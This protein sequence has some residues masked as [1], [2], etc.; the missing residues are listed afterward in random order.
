[1]ASTT[2]INTNAQVARA[3]AR[4][5]P[6]AYPRALEELNHSRLEA[7]TYLA[8]APVIDV[9]ERA[10]RSHLVLVLA[11][12]AGS[13]VRGASGT[14]HGISC[15]LTM[16]AKQSK[17]TGF[18]HEAVRFSFQQCTHVIPKKNKVILE[19]VSGSVVGGQ[20]LAIVGPSGA[21]KTM[22]MKLLTLENAPGAR[23]GIVKLDG[24]VLGPDHYRKFCASVPQVETL[25]TF[26]TA[27]DHLYYA[28]RFYHPHKSELEVQTEVDRML[29][30]TGLE[31]CQNT[32]AGNALIAGLSGG[33]RRRLS[34]ACGLLKS[35]RVLFLDEPTSGLDAAAAAS[36]VQ[37]LRNV[38][39]HTG[40]AVVCTIHQPSSRVFH[41]FDRVLLLSGGRP[42]Y[43]GKLA[44]LT[45]YLEK[46]GH[47]LP[48]GHNVADFALELVNRDF[49]EPKKVET[50]IRSWNSGH[51]PLAEE[52][53][54]QA[55]EAAQASGTTA[56]SVQEKTSCCTE[57]C[58]MTAKLTKLTFRDPLLYLGRMVF[59]IVACSFFAVTYIEARER[60]QTQIQSK[61]FLTM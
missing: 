12:L 8:S 52:S 45:P 26:L 20:M 33:Q 46:L 56:G 42:C 57:M 21:G 14:R 6:P 34:F 5:C 32:R 3:P 27:R 10:S 25:W 18:R 41:T 59:F 17:A 9:A 7:H 48:S 39:E 22:L 13:S 53:R 2:P 1:M 51:Q 44:S 36:I 29:K 54:K 43:E 49:T 30:V 4:Y 24:K 16:E 58:L 47:P 40:I 50:I 38:A 31:T 23:S 19:N 61:L 55:S 15:T 37:L 35:P 60:N 28:L 11:T